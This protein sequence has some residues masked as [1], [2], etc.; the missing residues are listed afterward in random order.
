MEEEINLEE[1]TEQE[2]D[3][4]Q[5]SYEEMKMKRNT[6]MDELNLQQEKVQ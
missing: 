5:Q 2:M 3:H 1:L 6:S 4:L